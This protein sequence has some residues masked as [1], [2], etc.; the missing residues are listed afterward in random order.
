[1]LSRSDGSFANFIDANAEVSL[2]LD[3]AVLGLD[4]GL[5]PEEAAF[6]LTMPIEVAGEVVYVTVDKM[7]YEDGRLF[8]N[9]C[10]FR[11]V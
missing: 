6:S 7:R 3:P 11:G 4:P 5:A 8:T 2:P 9:T 1:M 10:P